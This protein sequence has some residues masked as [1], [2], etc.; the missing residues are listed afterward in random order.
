MHNPNKNGILI[1]MHVTSF[2]LLFFGT[3]DV[4][5]ERKYG[6]SGNIYGRELRVE[7]VRRIRGEMEFDNL[8][9]L[10]AQIEADVASVCK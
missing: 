4:L 3:N 8:D 2:S 5:A 1:Q 6:F 10:R 9:A 7:L